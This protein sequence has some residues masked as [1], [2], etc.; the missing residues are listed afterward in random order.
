MDERYRTKY[1]MSVLDNLAKIRE[2]GIDDFAAHEEIHWTCPSCGAILCVHR[3]ECPGC[4]AG[5]IDS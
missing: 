3:R 5:R 2:I 1:G 4:G